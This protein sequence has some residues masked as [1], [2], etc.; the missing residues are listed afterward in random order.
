MERDDQAEMC[1]VEAATKEP[2][3]V[4]SRFSGGI[5]SEGRNISGITKSHFL[6]LIKSEPWKGISGYDRTEIIPLPGLTVANFKMSPC[7][8]PKGMST[9]PI[10]YP[11]FVTGFE[12][13][14]QHAART[15]I[16]VRYTEK[17][18]IHGCS[19]L[20]TEAKNTR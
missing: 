12:R 8:I 7:F 6:Q 20:Y 4:F 5:D 13:N 18:W 10:H 2:S 9:E 16:N 17:D 11:N 1:R 19:A 15:A 3:K 14:P